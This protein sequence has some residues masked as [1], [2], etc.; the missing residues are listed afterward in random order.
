[1]NDLKPPLTF[2]I[3]KDGKELHAWR[4]ELE[5]RHTHGKTVPKAW[6][7]LKTQCN[8]ILR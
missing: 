6:E 2:T 7:T 8:S 4:P 3:E 5:G 1:M